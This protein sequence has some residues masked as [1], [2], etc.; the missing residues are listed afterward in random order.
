MKQLLS[1]LIFFSALFGWGNT[2]HRVV[3]KVANDRLSNKAKRE[4]KNIFGHH[5]LAYLS[6]WADEIRSD[7]NWNHANE[8]HYATIPDGELYKKEKYSG[9]LIEKI[10]EFS[11]VIKSQKLLRND[12]QQALKW[13]VHLV[14][15]L[16]QPLHIGNG[17]DRGANDVK[18]KWFGEEMTLHK[19]WD[20]KLLDYQNLS[21][22]E[23][24]DFLKIKFDETD[25]KKWMEGDLASYAHESREYRN[26]CYKYDGDNLGYQYTFITK[27]V[28]DMR[29]M[30]AGIRLAN[31]LNKIFI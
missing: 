14:G 30:Q 18:V 3:G 26:I 19:V 21:Y 28:L 5:D 7:P 15:D 16:H 13:L 23:Y 22:T 11:I 6:V 8:W 29:L 9:K 31:L 2:G 12:K 1:I 20:E 4:I 27:P 17:K 24:A 10:K 25:C